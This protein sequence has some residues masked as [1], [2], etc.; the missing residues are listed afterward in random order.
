MAKNPS[1][2][3]NPRRVA[4]GKRNRSLRRGLTEAGRERL[5]QS[6]LENKPWEHSTG[7]TS[8]QGKEQSRQNG[9]RRQLGPRSVRELRQDLKALRGL[10][11]DMREARMSLQGL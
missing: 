11:H 8:R 2:A 9:K 4:A 3:K 10:L 1:A 5:R 7:P 6:A